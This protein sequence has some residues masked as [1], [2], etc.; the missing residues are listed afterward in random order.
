MTQNFSDFQKIL[1]AVLF[2]PVSSGAGWCL[3][4]IAGVPCLL[5]NILT[6]QN[7]GFERLIVWA[8]QPVLEQK[9]FFGFN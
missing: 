7:L 2:L 1:T 6:L 5:R 3:K 8:E 9:K 4:K